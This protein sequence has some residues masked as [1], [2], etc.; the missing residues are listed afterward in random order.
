MNNVIEVIIIKC[1]IDII[2]CIANYFIDY[3]FELFFDL[4]RKIRTVNFV[5]DL[6]AD[7]IEVGLSI[8][9]CAFKC[10]VF[11]HPAADAISV[12]EFMSKGCCKCRTTNCANL[13]FRTCCRRSGRMPFCG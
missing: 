8:F 10:D 4:V 1:T 9:L 7:F 11:R 5:F 2:L 13:S 12:F 6:L 3:I